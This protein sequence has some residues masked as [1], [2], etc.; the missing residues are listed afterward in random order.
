VA[1]SK[2]GQMT[3][4]EWYLGS[5]GSLEH[6][7]QVYQTDADKIAM[8]DGLEQ[9]ILEQQDTIEQSFLKIGA[10]LLKFEEDQL[11][12]AK[13]AASMKIWLQGPEFSFS[14]E[15]AT[16]L[17]RI[18]KDLLPI[19][20]DRPPLPVSKMA[21]L[22]PMLPNATEDEVI[23]AYDEIQELTVKDAKARLREIRGL[24]PRGMP[25]TFF[26]SVRIGTEYHRVRINRTGEDGDVYTMTPEPILVKPKDFALFVERALGN[27]FIEYE[28][29]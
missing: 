14:Y 11:Y 24:E 21:E 15:H 18:V 12:L 28:G 8:A 6:Y 25:V 7:P 19:L 20:G 22:L 3:D 13:G 17:M 9:Y 23:D 2:E 16:K 1:E 10:A 26:A 4:K 29:N 27:A 5:D